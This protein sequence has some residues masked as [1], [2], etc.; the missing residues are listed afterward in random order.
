MSETLY[1]KYRPK[2][3]SEIIGQVHIVRTLSNSIKNNRVGQA[4]LFT[5]P[6]GT[7]KTSIARILAKTINCENL[8][9]AIPCEKCEACKIITAGKSLDIIEIDAA[10]NTGV[11]NI[12]ELKETVA[13]SNASLKYK[14][15]IIDEVHML[16]TGAFNALLKTLEEPPAHVVFIL[17]TT[18]IHKVPETILS[19]CQRFD[20]ARLPIGNIIEKLALIAKAEKVKIESK[21]LEMIAISAEGGMRDAESLLGQIISLEDKNITLKE[22]E[23]ILGTADKKT[24]EII[25][26]MIFKKNSSGAISKINELLENGYDLEVF[27]KSLINYL[28][29]LM[30]I[31]IDSN[32]KKYFSSEMTSERL[33]KMEELS[34]GA[35]LSIIISS[36]NLFLEAQSKISSF[37]LPQLPLE[38]A[39]IKAT[40]TF[41]TKKIEYEI[42]TPKIP[43][44]PS[45]EGARRADEGE[46]S[47]DK[48]NISSNKTEK[49]EDSKLLITNCKLQEDN[50]NTN[51][52]LSTI[53]SNWQKLLIDIRP[54][55]HSLSALLSNCQPT[56]TE[57][58]IITLG[59]PYSF[60]CERLNDKTNRLTVEQVF[61]KILKS[62]IKINIELDKNL[63]LKKEAEPI[64]KSEQNSLLTDALEI[65]GGK[66]V[67]E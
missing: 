3:F 66:V 29:Q 4:Y 61:S 27:N 55:N 37:I 7:G 30:I 47:L 53:K 63:V 67:E 64:K 52:D 62:E 24:A 12:R 21:A 54:Y 18:E 40:Q 46:T 1:R 41:P 17:A 48:K 57:K 11:D 44:P 8:S 20:F 35:E 19:R 60:Y 39:I 34:K 16:S 22:V 42:E 15:Y 49:K 59:T 58:N 6:R 28:R 14:V 36:I 10:S 50:V 56:K 9:D 31:K 5:G 38:I 13:L 33:E 51:I 32:L 23:E 45:G 43:L 26:E 2:N 65:M 25:A